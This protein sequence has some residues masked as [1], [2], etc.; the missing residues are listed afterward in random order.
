MGAYYKVHIL[1]AK[2][3]DT[4]KKFNLKSYKGK[5]YILQLVHL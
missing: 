3:Y 5:L 2:G 1:Y 4:K